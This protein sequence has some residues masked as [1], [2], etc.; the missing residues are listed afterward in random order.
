MLRSLYLTL[1]FF[2]FI[3]V[4]LAAPFALSL[5]YIWISIFRPQAIAYTILPSIPVSLIMGALAVG[6]YLLR[7]RRS[8]PHFSPVLGMMAAMAAWVTLTTAVFAVAPDSAWEKWD[9]AFKTIVFSGFMVFVFRSRIQIEALLQVLLFS[10]AAH[11]LPVGIKVVLSGG[12]Y[13]QALGL[14]G[15]N[16]GFGEGATL[17]AVA[18]MCI[19]IALFLAKHNRLM[20]A[21]PI[22]RLGYIGMAGLAVMATIGTYQRTGLVGLVVLAITFWV[23]SRQ[24]LLVGTGLGIGAIVFALSVSSNWAERMS[25]ISEYQSEGSALGRILVWQWTLGFVANNPFG[26]GFHSYMINEFTSQPT[27]EYPNG[28]TVRGKAFH[29]IYFEALGEHGWIGL[30][31][32]LAINIATLLS[33]QRVIRRTRGSEALAWCRDLA[34]ALQVSLLVLLACGAFIGIAFQPMFW[35]LFAASGCL[36]HHVGRAFAP[37]VA[38]RRQQALGAGVGTRGNAIAARPWRGAAGG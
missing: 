29:S 19:P 37:D 7:D 15:G 32:F 28:Y 24:K 36:S 20:P 9:W 31:L 35:Y 21:W 23:R 33:L 30:G 27:P 34:A 4:G 8:P 38:A 13:G 3:G 12:G 2:S 11:F 25:T 6:W 1:A 22:V 18:L 14:I 26:G 17:A 5:G 10:F 16:S